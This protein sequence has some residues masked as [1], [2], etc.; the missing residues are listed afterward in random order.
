MK[1]RLLCLLLVILSLTALFTVSAN[2]ATSAN[3]TC[4]TGI[5]W[6][7]QNKTLTISGYGAMK[8][9][10]YNSYNCAP[11]YN[12]S[13]TREITSVVVKEGITH[14]GDH[15]FYFVPKITSVSLPST[16]KSIGENAFCGTDLASVTIPESVEEIGRAAFLNTDLV[17]VEFPDGITTIAADM[18]SVCLSLKTVSIPDSV[19]SIER[20]AFYA[21]HEMKEIDLPDSIITIGEQ[22]FWACSALTTIDLPDNLTTIGSKAFWECTSLRKVI[23][24][25]SVT[26]IAD[27]AF[28]DCPSY[29]SIIGKAGSTAESFAKEQGYQFYALSE[30]GHAW[31]VT[32]FE[33]TDTGSPNMEYGFSDKMCM[34]HSG[35][36]YITGFSFIAGPNVR[37]TY[38]NTSGV[39]KFSGSG[40]MYD[41]TETIPAAWSIIDDNYPSNVKPIVQMEFEDGITYIGSGTLSDMDQVT[42]ISIPD[43]VTA[44][45]PDALLGSG[46]QTI[47]YAASEGC[48]NKIFSN[49]NIGSA[50]IRAAKTDH[51]WDAGVSVPADCTN[52]GTLTK[53]C[54]L[55]GEK[56]VTTTQTAGGHKA[57]E[58]KITKSATCTESGS[59]YRVCKGC[60]QNK[61]TMTIPPLTHKYGNWTTVKSP[62][63]TEK[64]QQQRV[65]NNDKTHIDYKDIP[66][67]G[68]SW[69]SD[70]TVD[71]EPTTKEAGSKSI[72]CKNCTATKNVTKI[73]K[74]VFNNPFSDIKKGDYYY[75]PVLWA[76]E[77]GITTGTSPTTFTPAMQCTRSQVVTFLWRACGSPKPETTK[78][79]FTDVPKS[80]WYYNAVLWAA[81]TG[82]T[83]GTSPT[84]FSPDGIVTRSQF[85]TFLYRA[86]GSPAVEEGSP[87]QD[88][89]NAGAWYYKAVIWA[90]RFGITGGTGGPFFS[91][92]M[93][94]DRAQ[95]VT[96][97]YRYYANTPITTP[98]GIILSSTALN[99][100][101]G[102]S[103]PVTLTATVT[104]DA[105]A[106]A[107]VTWTSSNTKVARVSSNGIVTAV[108]TGTA[109]ITATAGGATNNCTVTVTEIDCTNYLNADYREVKDSWD[110]RFQTAWAGC[111]VDYRG[112]EIVAT[113][114]K[115]SAR[116]VLGV[117]HNYEHVTFRNL[118]TGGEIEDPVEYYGKLKDRAFGNAKLTYLNLQ[119]E[120]QQVEL[121]K[122]NFPYYTVNDYGLMVRK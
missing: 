50:S 12:Q 56:E 82:I 21:C 72:H 9:Y 54:T 38:D 121:N 79:P 2:A 110:F 62:T 89:Q 64:G 26:T 119:I 63:C 76:A 70:F 111:F 106:S 20:Q 61:E 25:E 23:I 57:G 4:G 86:A 112:H 5:N 35:E 31:N 95:T 94:C 17:S 83:T 65:C 104:P 117:L 102:L 37:G 122:Y 1:K 118:T 66:S 99:M 77:E 67:S 74:L 87:F 88:I 40:K 98:S 97:L 41:F 55:C 107:T 53:T 27:D 24:P 49:V 69:N 8:D 73:D 51:I 58:W 90:C 33:P 16:L 100:R 42:Y 18:F 115:F 105:A 7:L 28:E 113:V 59:K 30:D 29:L 44:M 81:E 43:S 11:W 10:G 13:Y 108:G 45:A 78:N 103:Q 14:I 120:A 80:S 92:D 68:H 75:D 91:P 85:V 34:I 60:G 84:T 101:V 6:S 15:A 22:A 96:F 93:T 32:T 19:T 47:D 114:V 71:K 48:W 36:Y 52:D 46:L 3:G 39:L 109:T 116:S